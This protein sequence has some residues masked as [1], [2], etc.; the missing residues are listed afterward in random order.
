[1]LAKDYNLKL[2]VGATLMS[3]FACKDLRG[4]QN[5]LKMPTLLESYASILSH[6]QSSPLPVLSTARFASVKA[7]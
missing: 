6:Q 7:Q 3:G 5:G 1:M 2:Y 4:L